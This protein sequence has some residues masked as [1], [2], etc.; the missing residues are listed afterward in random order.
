VATAQRRDGVW[1][2]WTGRH[3]APLQLRAH[4]HPRVPTTLSPAPLPLRLPRPPDV[5]NRI[6]ETAAGSAACLPEAAAA[7]TCLGGWGR[8]TAA[9]ED[10]R[11]KAAADGAEFLFLVSWGL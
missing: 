1:R 5:H 4:R 10:A 7:G 3:S 11:K 8:I 6:E 9:V 2:G